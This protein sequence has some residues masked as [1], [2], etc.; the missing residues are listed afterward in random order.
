MVTIEA[1]APGR[2]RALAPAWRSTWSSSSSYTSCDGRA[3]SA[4]SWGDV[5]TRDGDAFEL[6]RALETPVEYPAG[7]R[8][9]WRRRD[10]RPGSETRSSAGSASR[11]SRYSASST[12]RRTRSLTER[13][14]S[15]RYAGHQVQPGKALA[16]LGQRGWVARPEEGLR[17]TFHD[18]KLSAILLLAVHGQHRGR[19]F[20][21]FAEEDPK[22]AE[23]MA[24]ILLLARDAEIKDP[25]ILEQLHG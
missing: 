4:S 2:T 19:I 23:V 15:R 17:R 20:L 25:T 5:V 14:V 22:T 18:A 10:G 16:L 3:R 6:L 24:K 1:R 11:S 12:C 13:D 9:T 21:P 8:S 7:I